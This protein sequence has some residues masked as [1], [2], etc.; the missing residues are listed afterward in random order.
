EIKGQAHLLAAYTCTPLVKFP[1]EQLKPGEKIKGTTI[2]ELGNRNVPLDMV[3]YSKGGKDFILMANN[4]RGVMKITTENID[5]IEAITKNPAT[6]TAGLTYETIESLKG[7]QQLAKLDNERAV[8]LVRSA[9]GKL[10]LQ[11]ID[12]P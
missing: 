10:D 9:E 12:L 7:V 8:A 6:L 4:A 11:T 5:K 2:A 1:V 3:V